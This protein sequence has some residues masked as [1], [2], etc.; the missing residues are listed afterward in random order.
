[1]PFPAI[2]VANEFLAIAKTQGVPLTPMKLQKLVYFAHG[3]CLALTGQPLIRER[4][5]AWQ[6]GPVIPSIYHELKEVGNGNILEPAT[7]LVMQHDGKLRFMAQTLE[8]FPGSEER[9]NAKEIIARV[10]AKYGRYSAFQLSNATHSE[11][12]P[13]RQ[14]YKPEERRVPIPNETIRTYFQGLAN[15][16]AR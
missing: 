3:W 13:W 5:E 14:V 1:M 6:Y 8:D 12:T 16:P 11:G 4:I 7:D 10:F 9:N 2:A 15:A